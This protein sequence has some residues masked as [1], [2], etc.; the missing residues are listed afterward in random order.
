MQFELT[1]ALADQILFAMEDQN[2]EFVL[3]ARTGMV[4]D[5]NDVDASDEE[6]VIYSLPDW[7]SADGYRLMEGFAASLRNP[8]VRSELTHALE[9]GRGVFRAFKDVLSDRPEVERLWFAYKERQMRQEIL[10][11]YNALRETWGLARIGDEPEET[12]DL[13]LED[14]RFRPAVAEDAEAV[15]DLHSACFPEAA[16]VPG[17]FDPSSGTMLVAE[18]FRGEIAGAVFSERRGSREKVAGL[19][20]KPEYRGLGIGEELL[21]RLIAAVLEGGAENLLIDLP[22]TADS[23]SR[24]LYREGFEPYET[25]FRLDLQ[26]LRRERL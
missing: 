12:E 22:A 15:R 26:R 6:T 3:D 1:D 13:V 20:V 25:R 23:F 17:P 11:W 19:D 14:F 4:V 8:I 10:S 21:S 7:G 5:S 18:T 16:G 9:R 2:G 24:V